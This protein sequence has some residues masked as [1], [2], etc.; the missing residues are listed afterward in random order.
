MNEFGIS[1]DD[2]F[3]LKWSNIIRELGSVFRK[4]EG[5][6]KNSLMESVWTLTL[7]KLYLA[8]DME[9]DFLP[10]FEDNSKELLALVQFMPIS[11]GGEK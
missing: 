9:K 7:V 5:K 6:V 10:Q 11:K 2:K 4:A 3:F 1:I 8:Y